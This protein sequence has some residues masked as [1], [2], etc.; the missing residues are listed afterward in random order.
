MNDNKMEGRVLIRRMWLPLLVLV[1]L[2]ACRED[3]AGP[4]SDPRFAMVAASPP[5]ADL[6]HILTQAPT[7]P[8]LERYSVSFWA[9][10]TTGKTVFINYRR[11]IGQWIGDPFLRFKIPIN[12]LVAG[13]NGMPLDRGDSVWITL[14]VDTVNFRVDFQ[15]AGVMFSTSKPALL[16]FWYQNANPD[17]NSDGVVDATDTALEQQLAI[18]SQSTRTVWRQLASKNDT[19][20]KIVA[21]PISHFSSYAVAW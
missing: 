15:P 11:R 20:E 19:T 9:T 16:A 7:A 4:Q 13:A 17:L 1:A 6:A 18:W 2:A 10:R 12:G 21:A 14:T 3:F 5:P 8:M